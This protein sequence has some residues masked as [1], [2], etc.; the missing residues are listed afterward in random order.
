MVR[1]WLRLLIVGFLLVK[2]S[3][4]KVGFHHTMPF[5]TDPTDIH[6]FVEIVDRSVF[7]SVLNDIF[8]KFR[9]DAGQ[10]LQFSVRCRI[11]VNAKFVLF[12]QEHFLF[13]CCCVPAQQQG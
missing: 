8:G 1:Q 5:G 3:V 7:V 12:R 13:S 11:Q 10:C 6:N 9:S 4:G 2:L